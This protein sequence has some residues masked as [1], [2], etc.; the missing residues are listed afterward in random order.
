[1]LRCAV[2]GVTFSK[3]QGLSVDLNSRHNPEIFPSL[4]AHQT[5][6]AGTPEEF[7]S[8][9]LGLAGKALTSGFISRNSSVSMSAILIPMF[10]PMMS[11]YLLMLQ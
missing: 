10:L 3:K 8:L 2:L 4:N 9:G 11:G 1:M 6:L 5:D 7:F